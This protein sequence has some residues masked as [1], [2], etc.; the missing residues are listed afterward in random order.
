MNPTPTTT[1]RYRGYYGW[2]IVMVALVSMAFWIGIRTSFSVFF[3]ALLEEFSWNRG[4]SAGAQSLAL[5]TYTVLA[6]LVGW[7]IDRFGPRR[8][9]VPGI[10]VLVMGLV[11]CA[12]IKTLTQFYI[13]Y[14][15]FMGSGITCIG[16]ISYSAIL[17]HWF[18]KK[19]GLASGIAVSGMGLGTFLFLPLTQFFITAV[20]WRTTFMITAGLVLLLVL[21][22][23]GLFLKHKPQEID[24]QVDGSDSGS[25]H[26]SGDAKPD[27][28]VH[29]PNDSFRHVIRT[30]SFWSLMA[31]PFLVVIGI[32]ITL[33][34]NV[35]FMVDQGISK[36]TAAWIFA[37][38][39]I[40][41]SVFR[42]FW[43][44]LSDR[45]GRE[46]T[47]TLGVLCACLGVGSLILLEATGV[48]MFIYS[49]LILFGVGWGV[50]AP[51][52]MAVSAD[53]FKGKAFGFIYGLVEAGIG[54]G[55]ALGAWIAGLIFDRTSSYQWAFILAISG[56]VCSCFF[57]W[58]A[59][60]RKVKL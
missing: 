57:V 33:V 50:T 24:Q 55:G 25:F 45:W 9:I 22:L 54:F 8:V 11:M 58:M 19:R 29:N 40:I 37:M 21:P 23:N 17:A 31:F 6:P 5:I 3:V 49:F 46:K 35:Q 52:F 1:L 42:I 15:V 28:S 30:F 48:R 38:V 20:G 41:S 16:I 44:W 39:G 36:M 53:L 2:I 18:Q 10:L 32:Y 12:T 51:M 13:Y 26:I 7:L 34:H 4:D 14:G 47:F 59:A 27:G 56:M 43:G 60:P